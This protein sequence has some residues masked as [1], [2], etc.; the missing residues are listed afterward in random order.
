MRILI[1]DDD[2]LLVK[3]LKM[4]LEK[5][6]YAVDCAGDGKTGSYLARTNEYDLVI[7]DNILPEKSG[8]EVCQE[9]RQY[10][11]ATPI[12]LISVLTDPEEKIKLL[13][14]GAD[15][16]L[17]KP[18]NQE[19]LLARIRALLRRQKTLHSPTLSMGHIELDPIRNAVLIRGKDAGFTR[20]E[21]SI[22]EYFLRN[23]GQTLSRSSLMEHVWGMESDLLSRTVETHISN[24]RK[25]LGDR[26]HRLLRSI[27][28]F[29]YR[30][31]PVHEHE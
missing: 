30:L 17:A 2:A 23:Q 29:G 15:D 18:Y 7:L 13:N 26:N 8:L 6:S 31:E 3:C 28:G 16:Y 10:K 14:S 1:V 19:E 20:K 25:K 27:P 12:L 22:L 9:I 24:I 5:A 11:K 4:I 21:F